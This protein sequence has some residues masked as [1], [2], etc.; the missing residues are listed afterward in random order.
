M[1]AVSNTSPLILLE[2][3]GY[4][5]ILGNLFEKLIIPPE[6]D[7]EWLRPGNYVV[8]D[9]ISVRNLSDTA[10][11]YA[12]SLYRKM[13]KGEAQAIALFSEIKADFILLDDLK[14]RKYADSQGL[15]LAGTV[16]ILIT[17]KKKGLIPELRPVL[18]I[19]KT[20]RI[21]LSD[22]V[23]RKALMLANEKE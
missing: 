10:M 5:W 13:D 2:K 20:Q 8:P 21:R 3:T 12:E 11:S 7:K 22:D 23:F 14:G 17:A 4:F 6:V 15:P 16:G 1:I 18:E 9:W 19:L